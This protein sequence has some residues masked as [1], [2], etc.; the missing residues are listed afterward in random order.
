MKRCGCERDSASERE[1][2][3]EAG[4]PDC[5]IKRRRCK[6]SL[7][8]L[9]LCRS[10][11]LPSCVCVSCFFLFVPP[12]CFFVSSSCVVRHFLIFYLLIVFFYSFSSVLFHKSK[13]NESG[14][15]IL[16]FSHNETV[17]PNK[18]GD[19][20]EIVPV[21]H[22]GEQLKMFFCFFNH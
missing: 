19:F 4:E 2:V 16:I 22:C 21:F 10:L 15:S 20:T 12:C 14:E 7:S 9:S 1:S 18:D 17:F 3:E 6:S 11:T 13:M 5:H 8:I